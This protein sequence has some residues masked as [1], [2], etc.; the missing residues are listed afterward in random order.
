MNILELQVCVHI[1]LQRRQLREQYQRLRGP[2][3]QEQRD[4]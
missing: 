1:W 2:A 3:M 4:V